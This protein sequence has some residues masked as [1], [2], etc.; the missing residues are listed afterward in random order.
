M[1]T[2]SSTVARG[3][4]I[5]AYVRGWLTRRGYR[6]VDRN[7]RTRGGEIDIVAWH[8]E[9]LC[10]VEV[11]S[12]HDTLH[13]GPLATVSRRKQ[14]RLVRAARYYLASFSEPPW[15]RFDVVG[16]TLRPF[17]VELIADAFRA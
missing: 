2:P 17:V 10:F 5:E 11:R 15:V 14:A 13:G 12:T 9:T 7:V 1:D 3:A 8:R 6:I 16:V 4:A